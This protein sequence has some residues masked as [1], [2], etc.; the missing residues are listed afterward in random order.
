MLVTVL[1]FI[2]KTTDL[3]KLFLNREFRLWYFT[4]RGEETIRRGLLKFS[5]LWLSI[6]F[7]VSFYVKS[8]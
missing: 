1:L 4:E 7:F 8:W 6:G 2:P 5:E 3:F